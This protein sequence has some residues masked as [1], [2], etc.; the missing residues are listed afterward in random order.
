SSSSNGIENQ[1]G[2]DSSDDSG[3]GSSSGESDGGSYIG[4]STGSGASGGSSSLSRASSKDKREGKGSAQ[5]I[6]ST[7]S[8]SSSGTGSE[9]GSSLK[10]RMKNLF[11]KPKD[12]T[13]KE[14]DI[15]NLDDRVDP[16]LLAEVKEYDAVPTDAA[17]YGK[18]AFWDERYS[19]NEEAFEWYHSW[20]TLAPSLT[21]YMDEDDEILVCGCGNSELSVDMYDDGFENIVN[22]DVSRVVIDQMSDL[23]KEYNM[24]WLAMD[25]TRTNFPDEH[26]DV[27][28]DKGCLDAIVCSMDGNR[29]ARAYLQELDRIL[30]PEA[31]YICVS[32]AP[33]EDR[34]E[35]LEYWDLDNPNLCLAWDVH[36]TCSTYLPCRSAAK[37]SIKAFEFAPLKNADVYYIYVCI[38][39]PTKTTQKAFAKEKAKRDQEKKLNKLMGRRGRGRGRGRGR[40]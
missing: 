3:S 21:Q 27:A 20:A 17:A 2:G 40:R 16:R 15:G 34:L 4:S 11:K 9:Y 35:M 26:F 32:Y 6:N 31:A 39:D 10:D 18:I 37:S 1:S 33:P 14:E 36:L 38:K 23:Y 22:V 30:E 12:E 25:L 24:K 29:R 28:I 19:N 7:S 13:P 5:M 8:S